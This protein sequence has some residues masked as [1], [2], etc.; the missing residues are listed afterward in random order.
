LTIF[1]ALS[2]KETRHKSSEPAQL[3]CEWLYISLMLR[4]Q[5]V[6]SRKTRP[7]LY[8]RVSSAD[9][10]VNP[11]TEFDEFEKESEPADNEEGILDVDADIIDDAGEAIEA[12]DLGK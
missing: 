11:D 1:I 2:W 8:E 12:I 9:S 6:Q 7:D 10:N 5:A 3:I 4:D